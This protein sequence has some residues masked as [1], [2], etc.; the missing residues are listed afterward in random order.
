MTPLQQSEILELLKALA[1][2]AGPGLLS[3]KTIMK[4]H[5]DLRLHFSQFNELHEL[6]EKESDTK[7][8]DLLLWRMGIRGVELRKDAFPTAKAMQA[9][10]EALGR[11]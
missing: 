2:T 6:L 11:M 3:G 10:K 9:I 5:D 1:E 4:Y 7:T 8:L